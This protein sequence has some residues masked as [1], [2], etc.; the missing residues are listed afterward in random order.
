MKKYLPV[1]AMA[2]SLFV[3]GLEP[4]SA[5]EKSEHTTTTEKTATQTTGK[6]FIMAVSLGPNFNMGGNDHA[7]WF[8][9]RADV[10]TQ[11]DLRM[12]VPF[13]PH[14]SAYM[15]MG[16]SFFHIRTDDVIQN[17]VQT[18]FDKFL[19]GLSKVKPSIALGLSYLTEKDRWLLMP[20]AGIGWMSV[21]STDKSKTI[22]N[23][24]E[25]LK[26]SRSSLFGNVGTALGYRTS[27]V[28]SL[29]LDVNYR[30]PL[31]SAKATYTTST[32]DSPT[33]TTRYKSRSWANDLSVSIG[34]Q[35][36]TDLGKRR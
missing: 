32:T 24:T 20:R 26:I 27:K 2:L 29:I 36:Q 16:L 7:E 11:F 19:P 15:N 5:Q 33:V 8:G 35:L 3:I 10:S 14:W 34:I 6:P 17:I 22:N 13:T 30:C 28:C 1:G 9:S 25:H 12:H 4:I 31:Q 18:V 23:Q 21:E